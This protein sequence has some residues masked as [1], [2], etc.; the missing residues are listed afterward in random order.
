MNN[1]IINQPIRKNNVPRIVPY[2]QTLKW[3]L[4]DS[5]ALSLTTGSSDTNSMA[6]GRPM[7]TM[8]VLKKIAP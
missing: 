3:K 7:E 1:G 4:I 6:M 2:N 8:V 5:L